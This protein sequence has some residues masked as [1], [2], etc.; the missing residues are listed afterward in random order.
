MGIFESI[1]DIGYLVVVISLGV[2]LLLEKSKEARLFGVM[3]II[4]GF[5]DAFHL[6]S[7][8][9]SHL[10][11]GGFEAHQMALSWGKFVTSII[12]TLFY[13]LFYY[14]YRNQ[15][16]DYSTSKRNI[17]YLL[18]LV[19]IGLTVLPQ[20]G[21]GAIPE[22][23][24]FGIY[25]NIPFAIMGALLIYWV[26]KERDKS[27]LKYMS[28]CILLSFAFYIP[29]VLWADAYPVVGALMM[30][31]TMAYL[32]IVVLGYKYF[33]NGFDKKNILGL[34]YTALVMGLVAGVFYREFTK[35]YDFQDKSHLSILHVHALVLGFL[36]LLIIY[37]VTSG[38]DSKRVQ[39]LK[40]PIQ[41]YITGFTF[42]I[43]NMTVF[44]IYEVVSQGQ[45][46]INEAALESMSGL[47]H[48][49]L[50]VGLV[51]TIVRLFKNEE[52]IGLEKLEV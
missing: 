45:S 31:K 5:G 48:I 16:K 51:W 40:K 23:Y 8:V 39:S 17:I 10:S 44:G 29:V 11:Y 15:S 52:V 13:V 49:L 20:N 3:A 2:R 18:A 38:Y 1:F 47:G 26:Y 34:S 4:L 7:R 43:V 37:M 27:G 41:T 30:P 9:I 35:F 22:N 6:I 33:I 25:R 14:Y 50:A 24:M 19:R 36:L 12:M 46:T 28:L 32:I 21:W 42:T